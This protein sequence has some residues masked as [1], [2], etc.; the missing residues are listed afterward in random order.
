MADGRRANYLKPFVVIGIITL[1][2]L[3][4]CSAFI[5]SRLTII[6]TEVQEKIDEA[7]QLISEVNKNIDE[8]KSV[9]SQIQQLKE[10]TSQIN[11]RLDNLTQKYPPS[12]ILNFNDI[13]QDQLNK[14]ISSEIEVKFNGVNR[15][16]RFNFWFNIVIGSLISLGGISFGLYFIFKR[17]K[18][19]EQ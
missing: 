18:K 12:Q 15:I 6:S 7:N 2:V 5:Y 8:I 4:L 9:N 11:S 10:Q 19:N 1:I 13:N 14:A 16:I 17:S 3:I